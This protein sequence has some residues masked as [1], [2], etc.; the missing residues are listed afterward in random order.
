MSLPE[1]KKRNVKSEKMASNPRIL[2]VVKQKNTSKINTEVIMKDELSGVV[3]KPTKP[4]A[5]I[6]TK[7]ELKARGLTPNSLQ[8]KKRK[9]IPA[10]ELEWLVKININVK[11]KWA[12]APDGWYWHE[13]SE[14]RYFWFDWFELRKM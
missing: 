9:V 6:L 10:N 5:D 8:G 14:K 1:K 12:V 11:G 7:S 3:T 2:S 4:K 13:C